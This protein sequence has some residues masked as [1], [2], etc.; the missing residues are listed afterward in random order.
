MGRA[1]AGKIEDPGSSPASANFFSQILSNLPHLRKAEVFFP[2]LP[3]LRK[4]EG[5]LGQKYLRIFVQ[6]CYINCRYDRRYAEDFRPPHY[7]QTN[8]NYGSLRYRL[9]SLLGIV[10]NNLDY[11]YESNGIVFSLHWCICLGPLP[12]R[13]SLTYLR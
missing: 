2:N 7:W 3:H 6:K 9:R 8:S 5:F 11:D 4:T 1:V 10:K 13:D 12:L